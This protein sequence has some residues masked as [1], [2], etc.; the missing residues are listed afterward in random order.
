VISVPRLLAFWDDI[1]L[2]CPMTSALR[3]IFPLL[4]ILGT[5]IA[6]ADE[7]RARPVPAPAAGPATIFSF[8]KENPDCAE[9]TDA[10]MVCT[11]SATGAPQCSTPGIAC[12]PGVP[13]CR[14]RK[15]P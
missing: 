11:R 5:G 3:F 15:A 12:T 9:W 14:S 10:C 7:P 4:A 8:G 1:C 6:H 2:S 13:I